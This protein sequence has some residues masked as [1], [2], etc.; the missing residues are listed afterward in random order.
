M[1]LLAYS[2]HVFGLQPL[3]SADANA[4]D[5][6]NA[7]DYAQPPIGTVTMTHTRIC[8]N[9]RAWLAAHPSA[10]GATYFR[11]STVE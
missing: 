11:C 6:S 10:E 9:E 3:T 7:F 8:A 1:S 5:Y 4:Y 2:E